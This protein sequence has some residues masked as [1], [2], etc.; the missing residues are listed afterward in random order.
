MAPFPMLNMLS[1]DSLFSGKKPSSSIDHGF[2][3]I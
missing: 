1:E 3:I 2:G